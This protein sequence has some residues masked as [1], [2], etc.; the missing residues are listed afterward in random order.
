MP[1]QHA[2]QAPYAPPATVLQVVERFRN[3]NLPLPVDAQV[4]SRIGIQESLTSRTLRT[5]KVLELL[6]P[7][8]TPTETLEQFRKVSSDDYKPVVATWL[9]SYYGEVF[10]ILGQDLSAVTYKNI[11]DA[12]RLY[13]PAG[14]RNRMV[15]LF[16]GLSEYAEL[17]PEGHGLRPKR[18]AQTPTL[19]PRPRTPKVEAE[20]QSEPDEQPE[21]QPMSKGQILQALEQHRQGVALHPFV[22]G[23]VQT[24]PPVGTAWSLEKRKA[25]L[26]AAEAAFEVIYETPTTEAGT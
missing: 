12:F 1:L 6:Q 26:N 22:Q 19:R 16:L 5:L 15:T 4:L 25:W 23:L 10:G 7:D 9:T 13:E 24:L 18:D 20:L 14:Q 2:G 21:R 17:L 3:G 11:E 8:G